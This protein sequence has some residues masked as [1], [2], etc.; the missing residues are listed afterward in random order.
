M[1]LH[2]YIMFLFSHKPHYIDLPH[3]STFIIEEIQNVNELQQTEFIKL[4]FFI[5]MRNTKSPIKWFKCP[6][7]HTRKY[8]RAILGTS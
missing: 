1:L 5:L 2:S 3:Y 7:N 4:Q 6:L 8:K